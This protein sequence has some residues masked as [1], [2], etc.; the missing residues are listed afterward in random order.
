MNIK[1]IV[2]VACLM[3]CCL[4][5]AEEAAQ[6]NLLPN[7]LVK[8]IVIDNQ[9]VNITANGGGNFK[10]VVD[11]NSMQNPDHFKVKIWANNNENFQKLQSDLDAW[12]WSKKERFDL[13]LLIDDLSIGPFEIKVWRKVHGNKVSNESVTAYNITGFKSEAKRVRYN[14]MN[15]TFYANWVKLDIKS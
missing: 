4:A 8:L 2:I 5:T 11:N 15:M 13:Q 12:D 6:E 9:T 14:P 3:A 7:G 1:K 10:V